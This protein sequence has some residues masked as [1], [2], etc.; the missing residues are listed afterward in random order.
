MPI[1]PAIE[2]HRQEDPMF[3]ARLGY[4]VRLC[5]NPPHPEKVNKIPKAIT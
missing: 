5:L 1:I 4:T 2:R 3:G